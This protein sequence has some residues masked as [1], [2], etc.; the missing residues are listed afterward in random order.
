[1]PEAS[2]HHRDAYGRTT[3]VANRFSRN[4][5]YLRP[6]DGRLAEVITQGFSANAVESPRQNRRNWGCTGRPSYNVPLITDVVYWAY[7][8]A[9]KKG[10]EERYW[11]AS[12][13]ALVLTWIP[14]CVALLVLLHIPRNLEGETQNGGFYDPIRYMDWGY[15]K[16]PRNP[17]LDLEFDNAPARQFRPKYLCFL[18]G[19]SDAD[20]GKEWETRKVTDYIQEFGDNADTNYVFVSYTRMQFCTLEI[21]KEDRETLIQHGIKAA[22]HANVPAFWIDFEGIRNDDQFAPSSS[23][24]LDVYAICDIVRASHSMVIVLGPSFDRDTPKT[25]RRAWSVEAE[26]EWLHQYGERLWTLPEILL[27]P[28]E[29]RIKLWVIGSVIREPQLLAKRNFAVR[30]YRGE[31]ARSVRQLIDHYESSIHL[32]PLEL[33]SIAL[34]CLQKRGTEKWNE[35]DV[36]YAL[37]GLLRRRPP[38]N[39]NDTSFEAFAR[40]SLANHSD[41]L[42]R[43]VCML[44]VGKHGKKPEWHDLKD[45]WGVKLWDIEPYC[46]VAGIVDDEAIALDG[47]HGATIKWHCLNPV[48]TFKRPRLIRTC[49]KILLRSVPAYFILGL[50]FTIQGLQMKKPVPVDDDGDYEVNPAASAWLAAGLTFLIPGLV[51]FLAAPAMLFDIYHGK[52]WSTQAMFY[53][54]EGFADVGTIEEYLFGFNHGRIKWST[55]GTMLSRH[56]LNKH[57]ECIPDAPMPCDN[58]RKDSNGNDAQRLFTLVDTFTLTA[59][60][61]YAERPPTALIVCGKEG[62][63]QRALLCSYDWRLRM[64][65]RETVLRMD[66]MI[67]DRMSRVRKFRFALRR[68]PDNKEKPL[69]TQKARATIGAGY[70]ASSSE[71]GQVA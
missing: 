37:M 2:G 60:C 69:P 39:K 67:L 70:E 30:A 12:S 68:L 42:E 9:L 50:A 25:P 28:S 4:E 33:T 10:S 7:S 36:S 35:G 24:S 17:D 34:E 20:S 14:A 62:G 43:M 23:E 19:T 55:S 45:A 71:G 1:M 27:C 53:G 56:H 41:L 48:P 61:F 63:M 22:R 16:V 58:V 40:L 11:S 51:V 64:F 15:P 32:S 54:I 29:F 47:A 65:C 21:G 8:P 6:S 49:A 5:K 18:K 13:M 44:P 57:G 59:Y 31:D 66:T 26:K 52:F 46:Q 38:V 3:H